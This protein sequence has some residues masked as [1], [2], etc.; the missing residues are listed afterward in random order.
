MCTLKATARVM[1]YLLVCWGS[2]ISFAQSFLKAFLISVKARE[3]VRH[4]TTLIRQLV[5]GSYA[6]LAWLGEQ[7]VNSDSCIPS[8][9]RCDIV[10]P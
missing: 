3:R 9:A 7:S 4:W 10:S 1:V 8:I 6:Y 5:V 2:C